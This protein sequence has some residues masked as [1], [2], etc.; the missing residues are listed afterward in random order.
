LTE[1]STYQDVN[2]FKR[3]HSDDTSRNEALTAQSKPSF[4]RQQPH[5][6]ALVWRD[7]ATI[8]PYQRAIPGRHDRGIEVGRTQGG[9]PYPP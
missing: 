7:E 9:Q 2:Y 6:G 1:I 4:S 3:P 5:V 8:E